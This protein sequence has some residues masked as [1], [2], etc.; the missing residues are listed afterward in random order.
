LLY[1]YPVVDDGAARLAGITVE[2]D[3]TLSLDD[4]L[5]IPLQP[6][7]GDDGRGDLKSFRALA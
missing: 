6:V 1:E 5:A 2:R 4:Q 3:F 7:I